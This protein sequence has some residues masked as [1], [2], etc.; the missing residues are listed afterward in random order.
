VIGLAMLCVLTFAARL[1]RR[2]A[3]VQVVEPAGAQ[4]MAPS[5]DTPQTVVR[6]SDMASTNASPPRE[7]V[8]SLTSTGSFGAALPQPSGPVRPKASPPATA[9]AAPPSG[10]QIQ[11]A[12]R[13]VPIVMFTTSWCPTCARARS[14]FQ[15]NGIRYAERDIDH[16]NAALDELKR[17]SGATLI[18]T[19]DIDGKLLRSGF[20]PSAI[21][22]TL[23]ASVE[24]R[25]GV[26][27]IHVRFAER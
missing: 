5:V 1:V 9:S 10:E 23:A 11:A 4:E 24:K 15:A 6:R 17:R 19:L 22:S 13:G 20:D 3:A 18:P 26:T 12:L 14:F 8:L 7:P 16:D 21:A 2:E 25:L 27:G